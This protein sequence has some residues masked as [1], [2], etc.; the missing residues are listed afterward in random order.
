M[1]QVSNTVSIRSE[2]VCAL[3][4]EI[5]RSRPIARARKR[6]RIAFEVIIT[7]PPT[8]QTRRKTTARDQMAAASFDTARPAT[9]MAVESTRRL[10][11]RSIR[12]R[13]KP[14]LPE[15]PCFRTS[16]AFTKSPARAGVTAEVERPTRKIAKP[17]VH[18]YG[19][20]PW[21]R[22]R[23]WYRTRAPRC[24]G[25]R[26]RGSRGCGAAEP[27]Q[28]FVELV[29]VDRAPRERDDRRV[30][31]HRHRGPQPPVHRR[32]GLGLGLRRARGSVAHRRLAASD[33]SRSS[34]PCTRRRCRGWRRSRSTSATSRAP[35]PRGRTT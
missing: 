3:A 33:C 8:R 5:R 14:A 13:P 24:G 28:A 6:E 2:T 22:S 29:V 20:G 34:G 19:V 12:T 30:A 9:R 11:M 26:A 4:G 27:V 7:T 10:S 18:R 32:R 23:R 35:S 16:C 21:R 25:A 1:S 15:T 17:S 31:E